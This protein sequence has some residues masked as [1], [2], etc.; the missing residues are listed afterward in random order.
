VTDLQL[1]YFDTVPVAN[2]LCLL[3]NGMFFIASE[4]G[5]Q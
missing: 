1:K 5:N 3:R 2:A 4:F